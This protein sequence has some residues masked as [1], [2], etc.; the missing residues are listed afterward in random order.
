M[1]SPV[2]LSADGLPLPTSLGGTTVHVT[3]SAGTRRSA[4]LFFVSPGQL[5]FQVPPGTAVGR[6]TIE[7]FG[8]EVVRST[9]RVQIEA[10]G[11]GVFTANASGQG[12]AAAIAVK[13]AADSTQTSQ[14]VFQCGQ[15]AGSC[16]ANPID[17]GAAADRVFIELFG[18][19]IRNR[20]GISAVGVTIGGENA[21]V[22]YAGPQPQFVG[23]DQVNVEV[24][25]DMRGRGQVDV[26]VSVDSKSGNVV[27][28]NF[29]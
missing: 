14:L 2:T 8:G 15:A 13:V 11:P 5:N 26:V 22:L 17:M 7:V 1:L 20:A 24:P 21:K 9:A 12:I 6:A 4:P 25:T 29:L 18:T 27:K 23:L 16:A 28:L 10:T 3:D 19:G